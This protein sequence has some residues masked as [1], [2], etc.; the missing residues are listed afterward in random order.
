M[1]RPLLGRSA[2]CP[3]EARTS[4]APPRNF[5]IVLAFAGDSTMTSGFDMGAFGYVI[6]GRVVKVS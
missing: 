3:T 1:L 5:E 2:T 4:K 6:E